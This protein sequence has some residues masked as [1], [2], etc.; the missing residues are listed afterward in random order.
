MTGLGHAPADD[1]DA[2]L[3]DLFAGRTLNAGVVAIAERLARRYPLGL[4][5]NATDEL[6]TLLEVEFG[7][8]HLFQV[9]VNSARVGVAK[10]D[11]R[12]YRIVLDGL[13]V[14]PA[15][16]LFIDDKLRNIRA[17]EE[18]GISSI[19]FVGAEA[20]ELDL[21]ARGLLDH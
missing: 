17:A 9:V 12:A 4:L 11:P 1:V 20:L 21:R 6:E 15:E 2:F 5:S 3:K 8:H 14:R 19:H 13:G 7:I 16:A 18:L 10:P